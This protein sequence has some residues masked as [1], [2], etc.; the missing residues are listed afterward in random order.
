MNKYPIPVS[1][2][3]PISNLNKVQKDPTLRSSVIFVPQPVPPILS[4]RGVW[5]HR[6]SSGVPGRKQSQD[7]T[8][9]CSSLYSA[10]ST[11]HPA[12]GALQALHPLGI[13]TF[14]LFTSSTFHISTCL[15]FSAPH[16]TYLGLPL[17]SPIHNLFLS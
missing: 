17:A 9:S 13:D 8:T 12:S 4:V 14:T 2:S 1:T 15:L 10:H 3:S 6:P 5:S 16:H 11:L 7:R